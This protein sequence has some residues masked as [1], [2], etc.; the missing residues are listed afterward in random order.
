MTDKPGLVSTGIIHKVLGKCGQYNA[1]CSRT[2][3]YGYY[4]VLDTAKTSGK[5]NAGCIKVL[6]AAVTCG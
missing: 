1:G 2:A 4:T 5:A 6:G 3:M